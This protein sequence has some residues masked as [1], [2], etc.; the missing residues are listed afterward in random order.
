LWQLLADF[1]RKKEK[2]FTTEYENIFQKL[3]KIH[4]RK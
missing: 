3:A 1:F 2:E 4:P